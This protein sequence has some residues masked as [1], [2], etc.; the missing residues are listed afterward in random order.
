[1]ET[2]HAEDLPVET[3][4]PILRY[5]PRIF[6]FD[7]APIEATGLSLDIYA[8]AT[9]V[10]SG[11]FCNDWILVCFWQL[12]ISLHCLFSWRQMGSLFLGPTLL[13]LAAEE[14]QIYCEA[15]GVD[16]IEECMANARV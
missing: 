6:K 1:M 8:R 15:S 5:V 9:I 13:T 2:Q 12:L 11:S 14:A 7:H 10:V 16:D 3:K 4:D